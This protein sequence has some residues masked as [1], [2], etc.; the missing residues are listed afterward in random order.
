MRDQDLRNRIRRLTL[1][2]DKYDL[3]IGICIWQ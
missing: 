3:M 1:E 2:W